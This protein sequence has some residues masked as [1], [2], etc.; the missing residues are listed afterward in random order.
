MNPNM[1]I[2]NAYYG[3]RIEI[4]R[5]FKSATEA[6]VDPDSLLSYAYELVTRG[7][8]SRLLAT[9]GSAFELRR[10]PLRKKATKYVTAGGMAG[11]AG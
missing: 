11:G 9:K 2:T 5:I 10:K 8:D 1:K 3:A 7:K 4:E 6:G